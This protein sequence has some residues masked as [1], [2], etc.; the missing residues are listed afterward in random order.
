ME[1]SGE[2]ALAVLP[3]RAKGFPIPEDD[4]LPTLL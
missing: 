4:Y 3:A 1:R 2:Q